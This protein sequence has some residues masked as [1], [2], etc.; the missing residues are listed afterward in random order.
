M[1]NTGKETEEKRPMTTTILYAILIIVV[2][3]AAA[4]V[5]ARYA[6]NVDVVNFDQLSGTIFVKRR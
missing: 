6:F 3:L 5:I 1:E 2:V 4:V